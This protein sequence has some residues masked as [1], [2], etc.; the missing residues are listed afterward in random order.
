MRGRTDI[1]PAAEEAVNQVE[2]VSL[3]EPNDLHFR[4][5]GTRITNRGW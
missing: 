3:K 4:L 2:S 5:L 1:D